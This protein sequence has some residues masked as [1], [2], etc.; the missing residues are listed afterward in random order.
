MKSRTIKCL[1]AVFVLT[2]LLV[3]NGLEVMQVQTTDGTAIDRA[4]ALP[5]L[6]YKVHFFTPQYNVYGRFIGCGGNPG[7]CAVIVFESEEIHISPDG[8]RIQ[9]PKPPDR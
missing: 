7:K 8:E 5:F 6:P 1:A 9:V 4:Y 3:V 2:A